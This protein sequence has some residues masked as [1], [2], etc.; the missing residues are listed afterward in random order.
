MA[1]VSPFVA[2]LLLQ[3]EV[4]EL[5]YPGQAPEPA[6]LPLASIEAE[7]PEFM[8]K[9]PTGQ[10]VVWPEEQTQQANNA[11]EEDG[12]R[13]VCSV[14]HG[15][16]QKIAGQE[17]S[18]PEMTTWAGTGNPAPIVDGSGST[19]VSPGS[20]LLYREVTG[21]AK[22]SGSLFLVTD[23]GLRYS[24]RVNNDS[25]EKAGNA[26]KDQ[27]QAQIRLGYGDLAQPLAIPRVWSSCCRPAPASTRPT[28]SSRR[29][30]EAERP[31][32][33]QAP[34]VGGR[35]PRRPFGF[36]P[37]V[38][39]PGPRIGGA[40][41]G[42]ASVVRAVAIGSFPASRTEDRM[43]PRGKRSGSVHRVRIGVSMG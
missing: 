30:P 29:A 32:R 11:H 21:K 43:C 14:Y 26:E 18:V 3:G 38:P 16:N 20:G 2:K 33:G 6:V 36:P 27:N 12:K 8:G 25:S 9:L 40:G 5:A 37:P 10:E 7:E 17:L 1:N 39:V 24:V 28:P 35:L 41:V 31:G 34:T 23:T 22:D 15:G 4:G 13:V 42:H 19:Y